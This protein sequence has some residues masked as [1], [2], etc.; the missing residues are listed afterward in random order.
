MIKHISL[1]KLK[2]GG[3]QTATDLE[4][5]QTEDD[6]NVSSVSLHDFDNFLG[7]SAKKAK[8]STSS[9]SSVSSMS[10]PPSEADTTEMLAEDP[11]FIVLSQYLMCKKTGDNIVTVL[12]KM[13]KTLERLCISMEKLASKA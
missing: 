4:K 3:K 13:N 7:G 6:E 10:V 5:P 8:S 11:L 12:N 2:D 1:E 9:V